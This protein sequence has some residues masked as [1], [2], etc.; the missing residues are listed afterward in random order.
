MGRGTAG[1]EGGKGGWGG[2]GADMD[3]MSLRL[4]GCSSKGLT[5]TDTRKA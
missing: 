5:L 2:C 3:A 4:I 1:G